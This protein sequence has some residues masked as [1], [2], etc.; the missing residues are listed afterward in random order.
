MKISLNSRSLICRD[1]SK[2]DTWPVVHYNGTGNV[3][4]STKS[5]VFIVVFY[6]DICH[7]FATHET[8]KYEYYTKMKLRR[9]THKQNQLSDIFEFLHKN[10]YR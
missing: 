6:S 5:F 9:F 1:T 4:K 8:V 7:T 3:Y 2:L 10:W